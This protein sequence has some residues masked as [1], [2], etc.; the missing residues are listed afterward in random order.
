MKRINETEENTVDKLRKIWGVSLLAI[1]LSA[2]M[3]TG[4]R[5]I[6]VTLPDTLGRILGVVSLIG[7]PVLVYTSVKLGVWKKQD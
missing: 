3:L 6:G 2:L 1:S 5:L 7:I 4:S